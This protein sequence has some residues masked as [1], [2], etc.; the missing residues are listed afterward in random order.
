MPAGYYFHSPKKL[1]FHD[2]TPGKSLPPA[3]RTVLGLGSKFIPIP[4]RPPSRKDAMVSYERLERDLSWKVFHAGDDSPNFNS[5]SKLYVKSHFRPTITNVEIDSRLYRFSIELRRLFYKR[6]GRT[7]FTPFQERLFEKLRADDSIVFAQADKNLGPAAVKLVRYIEDGLVHL[8]DAKTY[9][10][11]SEEEALS[12]VKE[13]KIA[14][15]DWTRRW[16]HTIT[17]EAYKFI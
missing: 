4:K 17:K 1:A 16:Q 6:S 12:E 3:T 13:L 7:N 10:I 2:L 9:K 5:K 8:R 11:L 15:L 14:I